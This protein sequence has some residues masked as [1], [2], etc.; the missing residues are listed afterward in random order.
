MGGLIHVEIREIMLIFKTLMS[1]IYFNF[2]RCLLF[3][4]EMK[5]I[6]FHY[7]DALS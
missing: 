6:K 5:V 2:N 3:L 7:S 1:V 4:H